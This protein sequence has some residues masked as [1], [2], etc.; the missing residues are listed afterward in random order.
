MIMGLR[1]DGLA[2]LAN[3]PT[4]QHTLSQVLA[5]KPLNGKTTTQSAIQPYKRFASRMMQPRGKPSWKLGNA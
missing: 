1:E 4:K 2:R 5:E 3:N